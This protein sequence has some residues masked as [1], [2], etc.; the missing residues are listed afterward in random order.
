MMPLILHIGTKIEL[1]TSNYQKFQ[2]T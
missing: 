1:K 2:E